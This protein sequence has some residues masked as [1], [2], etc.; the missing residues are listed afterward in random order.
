MVDRKKVEPMGRLTIRLQ[1]SLIDEL[2]I[3]AVKSHTSVQKLV[4][5]ALAKLV[6]QRG[7]GK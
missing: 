3:K 7:G 6:E 2:K 5:K 1:Q 4:A